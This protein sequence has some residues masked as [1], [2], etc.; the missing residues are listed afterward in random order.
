M[1]TMFGGGGISFIR[2]RPLAV[3][4]TIHQR[5]RRTN[6]LRKLLCYTLFFFHNSLFINLMFCLSILNFSFLRFIGCSSTYG[7]LYPIFFFFLSNGR[8]TFFYL[9]RPFLFFF[10]F[11]F[12]LACGSPPNINIC[13]FLYIASYLS[14]NANLYTK[15]KAII[16]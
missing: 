12:F 3:T 15:I 4:C 16:V 11:F 10:F 9:S 13:V 5:T 8:F 1:T 14:L 2:V 6:L 7:P